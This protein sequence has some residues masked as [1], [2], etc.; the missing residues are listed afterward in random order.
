MSQEN[1]WIAV[2]VNDGL[3]KKCPSLTARDE[4]VFKI[5]IDDFKTYRKFLKMTGKQIYQPNFNEIMSFIYN[6]WI[7]KWWTQFQKRTKIHFPKETKMTPLEKA[8]IEII[9]NNFTQEEIRQIKEEMKMEMIRNDLVVCLDVL[10]DSVFKR[11]V[12]RT[13]RKKFSL[14]D[15][16]SLLMNLKRE[17]RRIVHLHGVLVFLM[18]NRRYY[19]VREWR[20]GGNVVI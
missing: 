16:I 6:F 17:V 3:R 2:A 10:A 18:P 20:S 11:V 1:F 5:C 12:A 9:R 7:D 4:L 14:K 15:K 8:G 19:R 13:R